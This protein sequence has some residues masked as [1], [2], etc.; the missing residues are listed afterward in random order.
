MDLQQLNLYHYVMKFISL[1]NELYMARP[2]LIDLNPV[3]CNCY[4]FMISLDKCNGSSNNA[5]DDLSPKYVF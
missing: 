4:P 2:T 5:V 1:S 3:K